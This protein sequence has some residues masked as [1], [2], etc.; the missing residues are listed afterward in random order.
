MDV[1]SQIIDRQL[2]R[3]RKLCVHTRVVQMETA[4]PDVLLLR[5][6]LLPLV[7]LCA[8]TFGAFGVM[9]GLCS[10]GVPG[11]CDLQASTLIV[12]QLLA[13]IERV[14]LVIA[15]SGSWQFL[16]H[17]AF[18]D[19]GAA[20]SKAAARSLLVRIRYPLLLHVVAL[21]ACI[22]CSGLLTDRAVLYGSGPLR[23]VV[24]VLAAAIMLPP[25]VWCVIAVYSAAQRWKALG[26]F[27]V[28]AAFAVAEAG[29]QA[30]HVH[31]WTWAFLYL[32]VLYPPA[33]ADAM[34]P[35][36]DRGPESVPGS[37][38]VELPAPAAREGGDGVP[39]AVSELPVPVPAAV[40]SAQSGT[41]PTAE[42]P[43]PVAHERVPAPQ[44]ASGCSC[45]VSRCRCSRRVMAAWS[46]VSA[47]IGFGIM[48]Q[49]LSA[50]GSQFYF[51]SS[52][53]P[54]L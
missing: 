18:V 51:I 15:V 48:V 4:Y 46:H 13:C 35:A 7:S 29:L 28:Y 17:S 39:V 40:E 26:I 22:A 38:E 53:C 2:C 33:S 16:W 6:F 24:G 32:S 9:R 31:H 10:A 12:Q 45:R 19:R 43:V 3:D 49:G 50:Y 37:G 41:L 8:L 30:L 20:S 42:S 23:I 14:F 25:L 5:G 11:N 21:C 36:N 1:C 27:V 47:A 34:L 52:P 54:E 44:T